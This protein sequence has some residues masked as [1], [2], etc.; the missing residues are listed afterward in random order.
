MEPP[1]TP[2]ASGTTETVDKALQASLPPQAL[3]F[4][5]CVQ[6]GRKARAFYAAALG[7]REVA[8]FVDSEGR[9]AHAHLVA[10]AAAAGFQFFAGE[11]YGGSVPGVRAGESG[12]CSAYVVVPDC[13]AVVGRM[14]DAG[15]T[16]VAECGD[17]FYGVRE[18]RVVDPFGVAWVFAHVLLQKAS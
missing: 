12:A 5:V 14:R 18:G 15:A 8:V 7:A 1:P 17:K 16:V 4:S 6:D 10:D 11:D 2:D 3:T 13:D 9:L